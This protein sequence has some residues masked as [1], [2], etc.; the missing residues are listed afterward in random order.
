MFDPTE[1]SMPAVSSTKVMPTAMTPVKDACLTMLSDILGAEEIGGAEAEEDEDDDEDDRRRV[2][3]EEIGQPARAKLRVMP[4]PP[5]RGTPAARIGSWSNS[6]ARELA[7]DLAA[8]HHQD[9]VAH[10]EQLLE[11]G[12]DE[13][14]AAAVGCEPVDDRVDLEL[15]RRRRCPASARP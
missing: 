1:R 15:W 4:R 12:G 5:A 6:L 14:H 13:E 11:L 10:G 7:D 8:A 9:A 2:A 3:Q